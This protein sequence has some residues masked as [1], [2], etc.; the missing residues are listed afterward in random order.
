M[1]V[2]ICSSSAIS[3]ARLLA[4]LFSSRGDS[5]AVDCYGVSNETWSTMPPRGAKYEP[6]MAVADADVHSEIH[7][8]RNTPFYYAAMETVLLLLVV[9]LAKKPAIT[10]RTKL[11]KQLV[12]YFI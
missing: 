3:A 11:F 2:L 12:L 4:H 5:L 1:T 9:P 6:P 7:H 8:G 10:G